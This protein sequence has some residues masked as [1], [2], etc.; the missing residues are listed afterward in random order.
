MAVH[1]REL[2]HAVTVHLAA[3][4]VRGAGGQWVALRSGSQTSA[5]AADFWS[6]GEWRC[7]G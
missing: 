7:L 3:R 5:H 6:A 4:M 1:L 2:G